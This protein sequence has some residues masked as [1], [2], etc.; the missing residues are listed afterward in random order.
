MPSYQPNVKELP[1]ALKS[2]NTRDDKKYNKEGTMAHYNKLRNEYLQLRDSDPKLTTIINEDKEIFLNDKLDFPEENI[3]TMM[4]KALSDIKKI[5]DKNDNLNKKVVECEERK[6]ELVS[7][8]ETIDKLNKS[9]YEL[10]T[11]TQILD[12]MD[13]L[14]IKNQLFDLSF[15]QQIVKFTAGLNVK[16][17]EL[18]E[19]IGA[20]N[21]KIKSFN[22]LVSQ[23]INQEDS[24]E[25]QKNICSVCTYRK[26]NA[27]LNPC[28]HTFCL[29]CVNKMNNK[30]GMCRVNFYSS[31]K[32]FIADDETQDIQS[33]DEEV[34]VSGDGLTAHHAVSASSSSTVGFEGW[35]TISSSSIN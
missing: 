29:K 7:I 11:K 16:I 30:C 27:C 19:I 35:T 9:Y 13:K 24:F 14:E 8:M 17:E 15:N 18:K 28:G 3:Y 6:K 2:I 33:D 23:S 22:K 21:N 12:V 1:A 31:I 5:K 25:K 10:S 32:M 4:D 20:N 26:I 34:A